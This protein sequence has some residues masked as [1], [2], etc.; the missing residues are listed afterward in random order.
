V[1]Y[2]A[3]DLGITLIGTAL[4]G[5]EE[6]NVTFALQGEAADVTTAT[7]DFMDEYRA[8]MSDTYTFTGIRV[9][10]L[11]STT[12]FD[13]PLGTPLVGLDSS[14]PLPPQLA[15]CV[16]LKTAVN[17][18]RGRGRFYLPGLCKG[19]INSTNG[20]IGTGTMST[21]VDA[22]ANYQTAL[23]ALGVG[24]GVNSRADSVVR[25]VTS[26]RIGNVLDTIRRR[27]DHLVEVYEA[28]SV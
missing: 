23:N 2:A 4:D 16:S 17:T 21:I 25:P 20:R 15:V 12:V 10:V 26:A 19:G 5:T 8:V 27:R 1:A 14:G 6:F 22:V 9:A 24:L 13:L 28:V 11:N 7:T 3:G 18:R